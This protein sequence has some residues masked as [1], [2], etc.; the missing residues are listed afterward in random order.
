[1]VAMTDTVFCPVG[2]EALTLQHSRTWG[3]GR[4]VDAGESEEEE[5]SGDL[6]AD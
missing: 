5:L 3:D 1:M 4:E 2:I 6:Q